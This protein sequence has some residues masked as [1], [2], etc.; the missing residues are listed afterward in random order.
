MSDFLTP[1]L[2]TGMNLYNSFNSAAQRA[3]T[4][5]GQF[6]QRAFSQPT[7]QSYSGGSTGGGASSGGASGQPST[8]GQSQPTGPSEEEINS[9]YNPSFDYLN[10]AESQ[11]RADYPNYVNEANNA[12]NT[13]VS[14][15]GGQRD[16]ANSQLDLSSTQAQQ[17]KEDALSASRRLFNELQMANNQRFG[18]ASSAG[19]AASELQGRELQSQFGGINRDY[20]NTVQQINSQRQGVE[21]DYQTGLLQLQQQKQQAINELNRDFQNKL[22]QINQN[23]SELASAKAQMRLQA[24]QDLRN[25]IF[26]IN[27]Q[28]DQFAKQLDAMRSQAHAQLDAYTAQA[29]K[30]GANGQSAMQN[31][32]SMT[33]TNPTSQYMV[34]GYSAPNQTYSPTGQIRRSPWEDPYQYLT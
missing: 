15:L 27:Q 1:L 13:N 17:R 11:L 18:G 6:V 7:Q 31:Y 34:G 16:K 20:G 30:Y 25:Q 23:R 22:L 19:L 14:Q 33:S 9:I 32:A 26:Q 10:Q 28:N 21:N 2:Y 8:G 12:Y 5:P 29:A 4:T 24:L 3:G